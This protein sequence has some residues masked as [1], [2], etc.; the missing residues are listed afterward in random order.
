MTHGPAH[1]RVFQANIDR[2]FR[3][4]ISPSLARLPIHEALETGEAASLDRFLDR[5]AAIV[6]NHTVNEAAKAY[7]LVLAAVFER[8]LRIWGRSL[9]VT[10]EKRRPG[11]EPFDL[12]LA[13][14]AE[15]Q[16]L[17]LDDRN[18]GQTLN[19]LFLV[20]NVF[21][22]GD[23]GSLTALRTR[24]PQFWDYAPTRYIDLSPPGP[25]QSERLLIGP[26]DI[27]RYAGACVRFWGL[28]DKGDFATAEPPYG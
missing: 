28:A 26:N 10:V 23:G 25:D 27:T 7:A 5:A 21:R 1:P 8:Q 22:H 17:D 12:Y 6:D 9:G 15:A 11:Y 19:E 13:A 14:C 4:V 24:A 20:A 16:T 18:L 2:L 3:G